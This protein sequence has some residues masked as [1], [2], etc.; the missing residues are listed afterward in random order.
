MLLF[1][2]I[3]TFIYVCVL[4]PKLLDEDFFFYCVPCFINENNIYL[5]RVIVAALTTDNDH[6][7]QSGIK[8][9]SPL[10]ALNVKK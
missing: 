2:S 6:R 9:L 3:H 7:R 4:I 8:T 1:K 5:I 10:Y